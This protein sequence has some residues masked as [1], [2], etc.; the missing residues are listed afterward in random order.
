MDSKKLKFAIGIG[1]ILAVVAWEAIS[2]FEQSK[3]YYVTVSE[4]LGGHAER[5][6]IRV[7]GLVVENSIERRDG[8]LTFRLAQGAD[9]IPV[10]Y[11][12]T[13]TLPDT[14]VGGAQA[15]IQGNYGADGTFRAVSIQAKCASKYQA[16][17]PGARPTA[18]N[19]AG[20]Q[21]ENSGA[22]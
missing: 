20:N 7:G 2:G 19:R 14:F 3:T 10:T 21:R 4:L 8:A 17:P 11:V 12:G 18:S 13:E 22:R 6:R 15:I 5:E 1:V 16:A 9:S